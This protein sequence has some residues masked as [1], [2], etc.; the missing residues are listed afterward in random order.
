MRPSDSSAVGIPDVL[1][2][3][4]KK[5]LGQHQLRAYTVPFSFVVP[6]D[7]VSCLFDAEPYLSAPAEFL[8]TRQRANGGEILLAPIRASRQVLEVS[9]SVKYTNVHHG[10]WTM[11]DRESDGMQAAEASLQELNIYEPDPAIYSAILSK[12]RRASLDC[13]VHEVSFSNICDL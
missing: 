2:Q 13:Y 12:V 7:W 5:Q 1:S 11:L 6:T 3:G 9:S 8:K 10:S 4:L